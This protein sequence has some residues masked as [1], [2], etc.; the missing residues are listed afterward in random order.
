MTHAESWMLSYLM[1]SLWQ[2][3]L[4]CAAGWVAARALRPV[5]P[6]AEHR[7]WVT[8]LALG[9]LLPALPTFPEGWLRDV[10]SWIG[11]PAHPSADGNVSVVFGPGAARGGFHLPPSVLTIAAAA[12]TLLILYFF[13]RFVWRCLR[14]RSIRRNSSQLTLSPS[15]SECFAR[16]QRIFGVDKIL[17][18][19]SE[20]LRVPVTL[21]LTRGV[22]LLPAVLAPALSDS[23]FRTIIE[24]ELAHIRRRDF[25]RN[26]AYEL[27]S[28]PVSYHPLLRLTRERIAET[29]EMICDQLAAQQT[30]A[31]EYGRSLLRLASLLVTGRPGRELH[32]IGIFDSHSL[33]RRLMRLKQ[34]PTVTQGARRFVL[35]AAC[36]L[37][38]VGTCASALTLHVTILAPF[39]AAINSAANSAEPAQISPGKA[40]EHVLTKVPPKYPPDAKKAGIQGTVILKAIIGKDG[41]IEHLSA[42]SGPVPL[43]QSSLDAVRQWVY[44]P[45]VLNGKPTAVETTI[46]VIYSLAK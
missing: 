38:A 12:Y 6:A 11:P 14:L 22:I 32:A 5:G 30:G 17:L 29:R 37:L 43:R 1:N 31:I 41:Q 8:V 3:P 9:A 7:A 45:F 42:V 15:Q 20:E 18:R 34:N 46:N 36:A 35:I 2:V 16:A 19:V 26:L 28:L 44:R 40:A 23:D 10:L 13:A 27:L 24:H 25:A 4:L 39:P 21:G 33:E